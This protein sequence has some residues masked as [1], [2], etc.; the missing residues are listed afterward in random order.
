MILVAVALPIAN[1]RV[2]LKVRHGFVSGP[3]NNIHVDEGRMHI[4]IVTSIAVI[5]MM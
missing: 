3:M 1:T 2:E 5:T 4:I